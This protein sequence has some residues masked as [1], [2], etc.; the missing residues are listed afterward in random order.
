MFH[1]ASFFIITRRIIRPRT[2]CIWLT[3][4]LSV[5]K[6]KAGLFSMKK[7]SRYLLWEKTSLCYVKMNI[8]LLEHFYNFV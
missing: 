8:A 5:R 1:F 7:V 4:A 2:V 6:K 3:V